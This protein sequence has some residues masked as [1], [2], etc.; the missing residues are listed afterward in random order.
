MIFGKDGCA[1]EYAEDGGN[2]EPPHDEGEF[3]AQE[4][5][6]CKNH[7]PDDY[8]HE[9]LIDES[10]LHIR[11]THGEDND[12]NDGLGDILDDQADYFVHGRLIPHTG[13]FTAG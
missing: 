8:L 11:Y 13:V 6:V 7:K 10:P 1:A 9:P 2:N 5:K 4:K 3:G 12:R